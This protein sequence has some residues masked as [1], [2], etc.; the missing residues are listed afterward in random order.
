[1][2]FESIEANKAEAL[3]F[4]GDSH[5]K[6]TLTNLL[7]ESDSF[8]VPF[9]TKEDLSNFCWNGKALAAQLPEKGDSEK[10]I[11]S[12]MYVRKEPFWFATSSQ[13]FP[14]RSS[15][16][17]AFRVAS[18]LEEAINL[19]DV[20]RVEGLMKGIATRAFRQLCSYYRLK[21]E[22]SE[23]LFDDNATLVTYQF[24]SMADLGEEPHV[25]SSLDI[26]HTMK[27]TLTNQRSEELMYAFR[28]T[29]DVWGNSRIDHSKLTTVGPLNT[30][31]I[32]TFGRDGYQS[33]EDFLDE[34]KLLIHQFSPKVF[35]IP[36]ATSSGRRLPFIEACRLIRKLAEKSQNYD[37]III[38]DDAQGGGRIP[39]DDYKT[40]T[41]NSI[42]DYADAILM[43][44][45]KVM[46]GVPGSSAML[47]NKKRFIFFEKAVEYRPLLHRAR[48]YSFVSS[49]LR[50]TDAYNEHAPR[51]ANAPEIAT[52]TDAVD[53]AMNIEIN[54]QYDADINNMIFDRLKQSP[55]ISLLNT[56]KENKRI[57]SIV[58]FY[59]KRHPRCARAF[60]SS[61]AKSSS[62]DGVLALPVTLPKLIE[63]SQI[64][65]LRIALD[66]KRTNEPD[67][68]EA[69]SIALDSIM[70]TLDTFEQS[71]TCP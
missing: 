12:A 38:L 70:G 6:L 71:H 57:N 15:V 36:S 58:T 31:L 39:I 40:S 35:I 27:L 69:L 32:D 26:G 51:F 44:A 13:S 11:D 1:M 5:N 65:Y 18:E 41:M 34:I 14:L 46:G 28:P 53:N 62:I 22:D 33:D 43:T 42:W 49:D 16:A 56:T 24:L 21:I 20:T 67:Y 61:L 48:K 3:K 55:T 29:L 2:S 19:N 7:E 54:K 60:R 63:T 9:I 4:I 59:L 37:P 8:A 52:I 47:I 64:D 45:A 10:A 50:R 23:V 66:P 25:V 30:H 68:R 17:A